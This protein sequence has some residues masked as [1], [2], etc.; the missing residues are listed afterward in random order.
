M[1]LVKY[2]KIT[3][4][5]VTMDLV[6][7]KKKKA[8]YTCS[9]RTQLTFYCRCVEG[10]RFAAKLEDLDCCRAV[11]NKFEMSLNT[12]RSIAFLLYLWSGPRP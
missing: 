4:W 8:V 9:P 11:I 5:R 6:M 7:E 1:E 12:W 10:V 3:T 2:D